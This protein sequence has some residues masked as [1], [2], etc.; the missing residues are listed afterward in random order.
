M[1]ITCIIIDDEPLAVNLLCDHAKRIPYL[2]VV[3]SGNTAIDALEFLKSEP[4]DVVLLDINMPW[5]SGMD[6]AKLLSPS[7]RVIFTTAYTEYA[8]ESYLV[9]AVDYLLKPVTFERFVQAIEK[10]ADLV[11]E[12]K[13]TESPVSGN[14]FIKSGKSMVKINHQQIHYIEGLKDYVIF[15]L[16]EDQHIVYKKMKDL[17]IILPSQFARVQ[18]SFIV[19]LDHV[20]KIEDNHAFLP[21]R[22]ISIGARFRDQFMGKIKGRL[23]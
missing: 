2:H 20:I 15:R 3:K 22:K 9:N 18:Q 21:D 17:E 12:K 7:Q 8:V 16:K 11:K 23:I 4:V 1:K 14:F 10:V 13:N 5:M 19:N 6:L